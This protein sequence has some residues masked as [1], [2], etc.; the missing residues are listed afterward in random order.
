MYDTAVVLND[1]GCK[2]IRV[3]HPISW[4]SPMAL[5]PDQSSRWTRR[6]LLQVGAVSGV[7]LSLSSLLAQQS[8]GA[9]F[10]TDVQR[11]VAGT[12]FGRA[13]SCLFI[14]QYGGAPQQ[15]MWDMKPHAVEEIRGAFQPI[16]TNVPGIQICE[17]MPLLSRQAD[18]YSLVRSMTTWD[19]G[20]DGAMHICMTG[21]QRPTEHSPYYGSLL[22]KFLPT[23]SQLPSYVWVQNLAGD[24]RPWYLTGGLL[25]M[26][27]SPLRVGTDLDNPSNP[28][29][30]FTAFDPPEG[31]SIS[32]LSDRYQLL[33]AL[34]QQQVGT[35]SSGEFRQFQDKAFDLV[36][37]TEAREAFD[38]DLERVETRDRYGRHPLGQ[39]LLM[40]RRLIESGV[41]LVTVVAWAGTPAGEQFRN[42]QTWDM[43]GVLYQPDDS[44]FGRSAYGLS[45][46]LPNLD[47]GISAL[48]E[49]MHQR[50]ILEETLVVMVGEF[51]RTPKV[52][53]RGRDHWPSCYTAMFAGG[54][55]RGGKL[56]G[57]TNGEAGYVLDNP[58][59]PADFGATMFHALGIPPETRYGLDGFSNKISEGQPVVDLF[60]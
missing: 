25:G 43:H 29:F 8:R 16:D 53:A 38:L 45:W 20:H 44:I 31:S 14:L 41:R 35:V 7:G 37:G 56:H 32:R 2:N 12:G 24:V 47:Q 33:G 18:K 34:D 58:V 5:I 1:A 54:G 59:T 19:G 42:V 11:S 57:S 26:S 9:E 55:I 46:V 21:Q 36:T 39:N 22:S 52:N 13:K 28:A 4:G 49:D 48:L 50:G 30:K 3:S 15:D 27:H 6:N 51:G 40:A 17:K 23:S 10:S 60:S